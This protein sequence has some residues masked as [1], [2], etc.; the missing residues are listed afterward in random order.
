MASVKLEVKN[1]T[2]ETFLLLFFRYL[3]SSL[4]FGQKALSLHHT[5]TFSSI[6]IP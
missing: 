1:E 4:P 6:I 3:N 5:I 2:V